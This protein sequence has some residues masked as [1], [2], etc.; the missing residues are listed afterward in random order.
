MTTEQ[1]YG[2]IKQYVKN[3]NKSW[4]AKALKVRAMV[5]KTTQMSEFYKGTDVK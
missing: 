1:F 4:D 5:A 2:N 3:R